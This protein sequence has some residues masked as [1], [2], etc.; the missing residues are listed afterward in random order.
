MRSRIVVVAALAVLAGCR[1]EGR[2]ARQ[3]ADTT[4]QLEAGDRPGIGHSVFKRSREVVAP[5][6]ERVTVSAIVRLDAGQ[7]SARKVME[8]LLATERAVDTGAA[9]IR[10]LGYL[11]PPQGH[12]TAQR[13]MM[14]PLAFTDWAPEPGFDSLS[15]ATRGRPYQTRTVFVHDAAM[16]RG[17]MRGDSGSGQLPPGH[18]P[19]P[20]RP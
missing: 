3:A 20:E 4:A 10:I 2:A 16:L 6:L 11:P 12:A 19:V 13:V 1:V 14:I 8:A 7:D 18:M 15:T 17:M 9:A 5:G